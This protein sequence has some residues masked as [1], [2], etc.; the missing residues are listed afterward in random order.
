[1]PNMKP[2][3]DFLADLEKHNEKAWFEQHRESYETA[4]EQFE[5]LVNQLIEDMS[6]IEALTGL[7]AKDCMMRIYRDVRFS[8]DK[9]PYRTNMGASIAPGGRKSAKLG[10]YLHLEPHDHTIVAGGLHMP[11]SEQL[12]RFR[13]AIDQ[14]AAPFRAILATP[15]FKQYFGTLEGES[16]KSAPQGYARDHPEIDLLRL[17]EVVVIYRFSDEQ[18]LAD[19]FPI[20]VV[21]TFK[22]M[23]PFLDYLNGLG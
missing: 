7:T 10:Y 1:M 5:A 20:Q 21:Q 22:A 14:D 13:D 11:S 17:K 18:V 15:D 23:K 3:L 6:G 16:L 12:T 4:R 19:D 9:S 2:V 8:K